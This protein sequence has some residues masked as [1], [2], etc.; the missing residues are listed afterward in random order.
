MKAV[1]IKEPI[2]GY[3]NKLKGY[4]SKVANRPSTFNSD[5]EFDVSEIVVLFHADLK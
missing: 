4:I 3:Q 2:D 5:H 1:K